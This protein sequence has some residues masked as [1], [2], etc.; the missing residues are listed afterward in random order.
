MSKTPTNDEY[1]EAYVGARL[2][3]ARLD[4]AK[5]DL[6]RHKTV[7]AQAGS[8][9]HT[10]HGAGHTVAVTWKVT[11]NNVYSDEV[12]LA[13]LKPG[14]FQRVSTRRLDRAKVKAVYPN[15]YAKARERRGFK[16]TL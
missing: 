6:D 14:Q 10:A 11:E 15:L 8:G 12:M 3:Q 4:R 9:T 2:A 7:L 13:E 1:A 16:V 5:A